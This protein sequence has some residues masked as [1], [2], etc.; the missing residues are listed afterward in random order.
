MFDRIFKVV[1]M[2]LLTISVFLLWTT[3]DTDTDE[4]DD[5]NKVSIEYECDKLDEYENV[6]NEVTQECKD[7]NKQ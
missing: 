5:P 2:V 1:M 4:Y 3:V 6:P 7:R